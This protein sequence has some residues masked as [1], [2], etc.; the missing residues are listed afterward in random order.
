M[1][2][3][4]DAPLQRRHTRRENKAMTRVVIA[5]IVFSF[6]NA[7]LIGALQKRGKFIATQKFDK[8]RQQDEEVNRLFEDFDKLTVPTSAFI[9]FEEEDGKVLA[10]KN[11]STKQLLG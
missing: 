9:T 6:N 7:A 11:R 3:G 10:L 1:V 5:D 4:G 8:M 2:E